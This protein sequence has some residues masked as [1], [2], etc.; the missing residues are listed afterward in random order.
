MEEPEELAA[1]G[2]NISECERVI[3]PIHTGS[4][5]SGHWTLAVA[6]LPTRQLQYYDSMGDATMSSKGASVLDTLRQY[7][8]DQASYE[9]ERVPDGWREKNQWTMVA[10]AVPQQSNG[11]DCGVFT[12][13]Y[14]KCVAEEAGEPRFRFGTEDMKAIRKAICVSLCRPLF[15]P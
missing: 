11:R 8:V 15:D 13:M 1:R 10:P 3:V 2:Y 4:P 12:M 9:L 5:D 14:A 6:D 7:I